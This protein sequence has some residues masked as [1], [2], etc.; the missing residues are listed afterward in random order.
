MD[1]IVIYHPPNRRAAVLWCED[2]GALAVLPLV[3]GDSRKLLVG[4]LLRVTLE[5]TPRL[6]LCTSWTLLRR[7]ALP[8]VPQLLRQQA[9][10]IS[11]FRPV[12]QFPSLI[13]SD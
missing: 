4:D 1:A 5:E 13:P 12:R 2:Q 11:G 6:R 9:A 7:S 3:E 10:K 8:E